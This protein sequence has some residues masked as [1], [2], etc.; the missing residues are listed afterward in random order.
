MDETLILVV[1]DDT[2]LRQLLKA[3][4]E[5]QGFVVAEAANAFDTEDLLN[6]L[7]PNAIIMDIMMPK[8]NGDILTKELRQ[9]GVFTPILMLTAKGDTDSRITGLESG[10]DDYLAKPFEPKELLLRL[11]NLLKHQIQVANTVFSFGIYTYEPHVGLLKKG[12]TP[13]ILTTSEQA[14][15]DVFVQHINQP[16]SREQLASQLHLDNTRTVDVQ[17]TRLRKKLNSSSKIHFIQT[18]RGKG[19]RLIGT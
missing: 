13:I 3:Y 11:N 19:Y 6:Y 16:I 4:L 5:R 1:D 18:V 7:K 2:R 15:L 14:L 12:D 8:K 9:K 10:A 17:V